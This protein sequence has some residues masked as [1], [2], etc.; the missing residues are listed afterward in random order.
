PAIH[1]RGWTRGSSPRV[2]GEE[3]RRRV[4]IPITRVIST[5]RRPG[6]ERPTVWRGDRPRL[7]GTG[8]WDFWARAKRHNRGRRRSSDRTGPPPTAAGGRGAPPR[9]W[10]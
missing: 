7:R 9:S 2:T 8:S 1:P 3:G 4:A 10:G 6:S 5:I